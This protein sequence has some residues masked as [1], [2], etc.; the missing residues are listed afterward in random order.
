MAIDLNPALG[1][2]SQLY[3]EHQP[4]RMS[5]AVTF[6]GLRKLHRARSTRQAPPHVAEALA[7]YKPS[8]SFPKPFDIS[9][10][11]PYN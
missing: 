9:H 7:S 3:P 10:I 4:K 11:P 8:Y 5:I 2:S 6:S 1:K